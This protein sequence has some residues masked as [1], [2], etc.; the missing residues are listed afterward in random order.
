MSKEEKLREGCGKR[1]SFEGNGL[2]YKKPICSYGNLCQDC[3]DKLKGETNGN[4]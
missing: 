4:N 2:F 1:G 3:K